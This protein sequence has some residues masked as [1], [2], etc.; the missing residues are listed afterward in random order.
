MR[1]APELSVVI[2]VKN[3]SANV[4]DLYRELTDTLTAFGRPYEIVVVDDGSTDLTFDLLAPPVL[5]PCFGFALFPLGP[6]SL[7]SSHRRRP[8]W[9]RV[10]TV[11]LAR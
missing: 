2:P 10:R 9:P 1:N 6:R 3:E 8:R 11:S 4:D 7:F 5:L